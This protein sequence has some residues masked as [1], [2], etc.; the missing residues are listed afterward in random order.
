MHEHRVAPHEDPL[1]REKEEADDSISTDHER[2]RS[3]QGRV[4]PSA[5]SYSIQ[6]WPITCPGVPSADSSKMEDRQL[7]YNWGQLPPELLTRVFTHLNLQSKLRVER[8]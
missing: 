8:T 1:D 5:K 3:C 7:P 2:L 6:P 4:L